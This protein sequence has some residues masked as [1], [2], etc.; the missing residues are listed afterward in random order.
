MPD[1]DSPASTP[2]HRNRRRWHRSTLAIVIA[3][4]LV[5]ATMGGLANFSQAAPL[6]R[7]TLS[8]TLSSD[9]P[10]GVIETSPAPLSIGS[11][12]TYA[13]RLENRGLAE[14]DRQNYIQN[15]LPPGL[16]IQSVTPPTSTQAGNVQSGYVLT[17][18]LGK[19][20]AGASAYVTITARVAGAGHVLRALLTD[21]ADARLGDG[22]GTTNSPSRYV[23]HFLDTNAQIAKA[24]ASAIVTDTNNARQAVAGEAVTLTV[25]FTIPQGA[26][27]YNAVPRVLL[28]DGISLTGASETALV[29]TDQA[30]LDP[31]ARFNTR[32]TQVEFP[33]RTVTNT[34]SLAQTL[35][36]TLYARLRQH[37]FLGGVAG[38]IPHN[39]PLLFQPI[40]RWCGTPGCAVSPTAAGYTHY[41][42]EDETDN[43]LVSIVLVRPEVYQP[44]VTMA[45][46]RSD[47]QLTQGGDRVRISIESWDL[48]LRPAAYKLVLT[49]TLGPGLHY[50]HPAYPEPDGW[51]TQGDVTVLTWTTPLL[52]ANQRWLPIRQVTATL[53]PTIVVGSQFSCTAQIRYET[54]PGQALGTGVYQTPMSTRATGHDDSLFIQKTA[55]P[56]TNLAI[57]STVVYTLVTKVGGRT[58][59]YTPAFTDTLPRGFHYISGSFHWQGALAASQPVTGAGSALYSRIREAMTWTVDTVDN[60]AYSLPAVFTATYQAVMS[61]LDVAGAPVFVGEGSIL[62]WN[63]YLDFAL[64]QM[65]DNSALLYWSMP[66]K[67]PVAATP[68][69]AT[70]R[71][72]QPYMGISGGGLFATRRL[73]QADYEVNSTDLSFTTT[74]RNSTQSNANAYDVRVCDELPPGVRVSSAPELDPPPGCGGASFSS[75]PQTGATGTLCWD[76]NW[77]CPYF[78]SGDFVLSYMLDVLPSAMPGLSHTNNAYLVDYSAH[79]GEPPFD[80]HYSDFS[81]AMPPGQRDEFRVLGLVARITT[82]QGDLRAGDLITYSLAYTDTSPST[83]YTDLVITETYDTYLAYVRADPPP[84]VVDSAHHRLVW[85][86]S[87]VPSSGSGHITLTLQAISGFPVTTTVV[88][89]TLAWD[90][91]STT[92]GLDQSPLAWTITTPFKVTNPH[93]RL[94]GPAEAPAGDAITY[95]VVYS[96]DGSTPREMALTLDYDPHLSFITY[97][98]T[99]MDVEQVSEAV[100]RDMAV[101]HTGEAYTLTIHMRVNAPLPPDLTWLGSRATISTIGIPPK[102]DTWSTRLLRP[103]LVLSKAG[104]PLAASPG[105]SILYRIRVTNTGSYTASGLIFTDTWGAHTSFSPF[106]SMQWITRGNYATTT[107]PLLGLG[108]S[109]TLDFLAT[110]DELVVSYTN[111]VAVSTDQT[112]A[113]H[114]SATVWQKSLTTFKS[115]KPDWAFPGQV[116]VYTL[117]YTNTA[118]HVQNAFITDTLPGGF[119][120]LE[121][122]V[123]GAGCQSGWQFQ[124]VVGREAVWYCV[125]LLSGAHGQLQVWGE[126]AASEGDWL[127]NVSEG[128]ADGFPCRPIDE[129]L[130]TRVATGA[131]SH[132]LPISSPGVYLFGDTCAQISLSNAISLSTVTTTL[133]YAYPTAQLGYRPLPRRYWITANTSGTLSGTLSLCY[134][135]AGLGSL[136]ESV[137]QLYRYAGD[138]QWI[139]YTSTVNADLDL[140]TAT[141]GSLPGAWAIGAPGHAPAGE[142]R[143]GEAP[144]SALDVMNDGPT[145]LGQATLLTA[146]VSDSGASYF[147]ALGDGSIGSGASVTHV[148]T[149]SGVYTAVATALNPVSVITAATRVVVG[150]P[151][152]ELT[153]TGSL[154]GLVQAVYTF[155]AAVSPSATTLPITYTWQVEANQQISKSAKQVGKLAGQGSRSA[156]TSGPYTQ[157]STASPYSVTH[158]GGISDT[159]IFTW[160]TPGPKLITVTAANSMGVVSTSYT[161]TLLGLPALSMA[162][163]VSPAEALS[164]GGVVTYTIA[165]TNSGESLARG[166]IVSDSLP[167]GIGFG[168]WITSGGAALLP[169]DGMLWSSDIAA[170][171][172]HTIAFTAVVTSTPSFYGQSITNT[173]YFSSANAGS[174]KDCAVLSVESKPPAVVL[175]ITKQITCTPIPVRP[176][177]VITYLITVTNSGDGHAGGV[178]VTDSL[179]A[180]IVGS[181]LDWQGDIS[182]GQHLTFAIRAT[183]TSRPDFYGRSITN[184]AYFSHTSGSGSSRAAF[185]VEGPVLVPP[186]DV[187]IAGPLS[188]TLDTAYTFTATVGPPAATTPITYTWRVGAASQYG[189]THTGGISDTLVFTWSAPGLKFITVTAANAGGIV[190]GTYTIDILPEPEHH[191]QVYL[192][193]VLKTHGE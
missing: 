65:A 151:P 29:S 16:E 9:P 96:N 8:L 75:K 31:Q 158:I 83:D 52:T 100:F 176:G 87:T 71:L 77:V 21:K 10:G 48:D 108:R 25:V 97:T 188:G 160:S 182:A 46:L 174:G 175:S 30:G 116:L 55:W 137:L 4:L 141:V 3:L 107:I 133:G 119:N 126:V 159:L 1:S 129:P 169:P 39:T 183:V 124:G 78:S 59:L 81:L 177:D 6:L 76:I 99:A 131:L 173:A 14:A 181:D 66:G 166:V 79:P 186:Q 192:P 117:F 41:F 109:E 179:P 120:Y 63:Q 49:A 105:G 85:H 91:T 23:Y 104:P 157:I 113:Q 68:R 154:S 86:Y 94:R 80:R 70:V 163:T 67:P 17:W 172:A 98:A 64:A 180:G 167:A 61:G 136:D 32:F 142:P 102:T 143:G 57:G 5:G 24:H 132:A 152:A 45:Y 153:V 121:H 148:Y 74:L 146:S 112:T 88:T 144:L 114:A 51:A 170:R 190:T 50:E 189:V 103:I 20:A 82:P 42:K 35:V 90:S 26:V 89:N 150:L 147:W 22:S 28:R 165:I 19:L 134:D 11:R 162:K 7:P 60:T 54:L 72:G 187:T 18:T 44:L 62:P 118:G 185:A 36:Y 69:S 40:L 34:G 123:S 33:P 128:S 191:Y 164:L 101:P 135:E 13:I 106:N 130:Y 178:I 115:S 58:L 37:Y 15:T 2:A 149:A 56:N 95:T 122:T 93:V 140:V 161:V 184:T 43:P 155:T 138:G 139:A 84:D 53:P 156:R 111:T 73:G 145:V 27:V 171:S 47:P 125:F 193:V 12:V 127:M 168:D 92:P 38:E 110:V